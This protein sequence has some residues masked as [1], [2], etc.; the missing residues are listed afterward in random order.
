MNSDLLYGWPY[1]PAAAAISRYGGGRILG[2]E[3]GGAGDEHGRAGLRRSA[4][5]VLGVDAAV[6]LE[7][8]RPAPISARRRSIL[9]GERGDERLAAPARVDGHAEREVEV[10]GDLATASTGVRRVDRHAGAAA[11]VL[12][13]AASA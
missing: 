6:D 12:D 1:T 9:P 5:A 4:P 11:R 8:R 2:A 10:G 13:R 7:R 3:D